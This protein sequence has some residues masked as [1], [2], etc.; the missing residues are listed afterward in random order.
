MSLLVRSCGIIARGLD[1]KKNDVISLG[2]QYV[3]FLARI[4]RKTISDLVPT[5]VPV[6]AGIGADANPTHVA[7]SALSMPVHDSLGSAEETEAGDVIADRRSEFAHDDRFTSQRLIGFGL[8]SKE[9]GARADQALAFI[10][11]TLMGEIVAFKR[12]FHILE[13][14]PETIHQAYPSLWGGG[15]AR[16]ALCQP[17][18]FVDG[19][20]LSG[21]ARDEWDLY[22]HKFGHDSRLTNDLRLVGGISFLFVP[23]VPGTTFADASEQVIYEINSCSTLLPVGGLVT[24]G[25]ARSWIYRYTL[26]SRLRGSVHAISL[27]EARIRAVERRKLRVDGIDPIDARR[28]KRNSARLEAGRSMISNACASAFIDVHKAAWRNAQHRD[29][30]RD[31]MNTYASPVFGSIPVQSVSI[32][33]HYKVLEPPWG[34][35]SEIA[36]RMRGRP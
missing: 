24:M 19:F 27:A 33:G 4:C 13:V 31:T 2:A 29:Q 35:K 15:F 11:R 16:A 8:P 30:W 32:P 20:T 23:G 3:D 25:G 17:V 21:L 12:D 5:V 28:A 6:G 1:V 36:S 14:Q 10:R 34:T 22:V 7:S 9:E 18:C 26:E